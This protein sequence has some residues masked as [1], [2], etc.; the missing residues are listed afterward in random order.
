MAV[1]S[2]DLLEITYNHP[3]IGNGVWYPKSNEDFTFDTGGFRTNDDANQIDGGGRAINQLNRVKWFGE[4]TVT[5]DMNSTDEL[6]QA[7]A[8]AAHPVDADWTFTHINGTVW[9]AKG[10]PVGDIQGNT[11]V[12]T[13]AIKVSGG[14]E[15]K[16]IVG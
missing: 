3:D 4:G 9:K 8:L 11:N 2:G 14:G 6:S 1:V 7:S 16:K 15:M 10:R 13:M 12:G 5:W